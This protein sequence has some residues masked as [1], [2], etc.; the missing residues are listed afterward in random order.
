[1]KK[2]KNEK[3]EKKI[4]ISLR[5]PILICLNQLGE[6]VRNVKIQSWKMV[7]RVLKIR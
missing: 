3:S 6:N 4:S 2:K 1:M 5:K 7:L